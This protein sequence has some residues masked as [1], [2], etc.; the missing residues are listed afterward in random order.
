MFSRIKK[1]NWE[2]EKLLKTIN[3]ETLNNNI[4]QIKDYFK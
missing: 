1:I 3:T 2:L 4:H